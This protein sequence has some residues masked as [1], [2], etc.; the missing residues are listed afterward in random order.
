MLTFVQAMQEAEAT[1]APVVEGIAVELAAQAGAAAVTAR[2]TALFQDYRWA[3][4]KIP[5]SDWR[6]YRVVDRTS[7]TVPPYPPLG[8]AWDAVR[9]LE[10]L[11]DV[12]SVEPLLLTRPRWRTAPTRS[13]A[14]PC[15]GG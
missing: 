5:D 14:S 9:E 3:E 4:E 10:K 2:V 15:G 11:Q 12:R 1:G 7:E 13:R 6:V 8:T